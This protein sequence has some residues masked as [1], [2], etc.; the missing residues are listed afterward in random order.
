MP[1]TPSPSLANSDLLLARDA[2]IEK[3]LKAFSLPGAPVRQADIARTLGRLRASAAARPLVD[4]LV[5][6]HREHTN[7]L[8]DTDSRGHELA[9]V[10][11]QALREIGRPGVEPFMDA[12]ARWEGWP[13]DLSLAYVA[14]HGEEGV[15]VLRHRAQS[16]A[17]PQRRARLESAAW[18]TRLRPTPVEGD[19]PEASSRR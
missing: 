15:L 13:L 16:E 9:E 1:E 6:L 8:R 19:A 18:F 10:L 5:R 2:E 11:V 4:A 7:P 3:L 12:L 14:V 17:D